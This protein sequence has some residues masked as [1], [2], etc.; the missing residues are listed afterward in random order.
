MERNKPTRPYYLKQG[1]GAHLVGPILFFEHLNKHKERDHLNGLARGAEQVFF[2]NDLYPF[3]NFIP[4]IEH[5]TAKQ[6]G[7]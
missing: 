2:G 5:E 4:T 3:A 6:L 1:P 7:V